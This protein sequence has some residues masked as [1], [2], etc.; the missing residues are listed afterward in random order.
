M[1][2]YD[3]TILDSLREFM[4]KYQI[5]I[6]TVIP[7]E[8]PN[9]YHATKEFGDSLLKVQGSSRKVIYN[10]FCIRT[11][12]LHYGISRA[13]HLIQENICEGTDTFPQRLYE[14]K[15]LFCISNTDSEDLERA[16]LRWELASEIPEPYS[17]VSR[18][19]T[20]HIRSESVI[21]YSKVATK[22]LE[23]I[24]D[25]LEYKTTYHYFRSNIIE[26]LRKC[27]I[28]N[29]MNKLSHEYKFPIL[30]RII[31]YDIYPNVPDVAHGTLLP[32]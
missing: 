32:S 13:L 24:T 14:M 8:L 6:E 4:I 15:K 23:S 28:I 16:F 1:E 18:S 30:D 26:M 21:D 17:F 19:E 3:D 25:T 22:V 11:F 5:G 12:A 2:T 10:L 29:L 31:L 9:S 20:K 27:N 7:D